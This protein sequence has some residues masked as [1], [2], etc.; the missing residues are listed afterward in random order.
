MTIR[1]TRRVGLIGAGVL[2]VLI[3]TVM[4]AIFFGPTPISLHSFVHNV[5][6]HVGLGGSKPGATQDTILWQIRAPRLLVGLLCGGMLAVAGATYQGIFRNP[7]ADPYILGVASGAG[8]GATIAFTGFGSLVAASSSLVPLFA[9]LGAIAAVGL[10]WLVGGRGA[11]ANSASLILSGVAVATLTASVQTLLQ[12]HASAD[13]L[14]RVYLWLLGSLASANW[15]TVETLWPYVTFC[16][17]VCMV[18]SRSLDVLRIGEV[19]ARSVGLNVTRVRVIALGAASLGTAVVVSAVGLIGFVGLVVPHAVRLTLGTSYRRV[20]PFSFLLGA[21]FLV[22]AD[23]VARSILSPS[24]LPIGV[25][26]ALVGAPTF[27]AMMAKREVL[28]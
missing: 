13:S 23:S 10:T 9:F 16:T 1:S 5:A 14:T 20:I 25:V 19:E 28:L 18:M 21:V 3:C 12:Q 8:L 11:R 6:F 22:L 27:V 26:T 2:G 24:E 7:L 17:A 15:S 4:T